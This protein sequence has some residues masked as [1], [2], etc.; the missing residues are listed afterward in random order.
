MADIVSSKLSVVSPPPPLHRA[1]GPLSWLNL[2]GGKAPVASPVVAAYRVNLEAPVS[3]R[4]G[5]GSELVSEP[6]KKPK[7]NRGTKAGRVRVVA[8]RVSPEEYA[9][10]D[11]KARDSGLS[12][13]SYLRACGLGSPGPRARRSPPLNA[14]LLAYAVGQLNRAGNN[15]NQIAFRLNAAQAVG[16]HD[17]AAAILET[18]AAVRMICESLGRQKR[19]DS[20]ELQA[21]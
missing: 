14:E 11:Q 1:S 5:A 12:I 7:P 15:L 8:A 13:G 10:L 2:Q 4:S 3:A 16:T 9:A 18:R 20:E 6:L 17:C 21:Q 19:N